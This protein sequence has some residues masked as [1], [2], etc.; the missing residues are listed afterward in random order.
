MEENYW[1]RLETNKNI[2][3]Q[4]EIN[5]NMWENQINGSNEW[6]LFAGG[7]MKKHIKQ[8]QHVYHSVTV[9]ELGIQWHK[10]SPFVWEWADA[11]TTVISPLNH[12]IEET[13][14]F[15]SGAW[16]GCQWTHLS[17]IL[18]RKSKM[19]G[20][21]KV[22]LRLTVSQYVLVTSPNL[23]HLTRISPPP[24]RVTVLSFWGALSD[25]RSGLSCVSLCHWV[26]P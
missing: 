19:L 10:C 9:I 3:E 20:Q 18:Q 17:T 1:M 21:V 15:H 5:R 25:E 11:F 8:K 2:R 14:Q 6:N 24:L 22:T 12:F 13:T 16:A 23:G 4:L 26:L 7:P